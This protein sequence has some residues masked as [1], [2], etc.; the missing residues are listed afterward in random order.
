MIL[1]VRDIIWYGLYLF[2]TLLPLA[3]A[4]LAEPERASQTLLV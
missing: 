4:T 3:T 1:I 2:L